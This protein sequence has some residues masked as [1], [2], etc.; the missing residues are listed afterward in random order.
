MG[1]E[2]K[3]AGKTPQLDCST[4]RGYSTCPLWSI[5]PP[6]RGEPLWGVLNAV[7]P[8]L[9]ILEGFVTYGVSFFLLSQGITD[10][11]STIRNI[12]D[13][14]ARFK[15]FKLTLSEVDHNGPYIN[16]KSR[17]GTGNSLSDRGLFYRKLDGK[18]ESK[19]RV[20]VGM[21]ESAHA[22]QSF[23]LSSSLCCIS[24]LIQYNSKMSG[25]LQSCYNHS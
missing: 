6:I 11:S 13:G 22:N 7:P 19:K 18:V 10:Y 24:F 3:A 16:K 23:K 14:I 9:P 5:P 12:V 4:L 17:T 25:G 21:V 8:F 15:L 1:W 20:E 2:G